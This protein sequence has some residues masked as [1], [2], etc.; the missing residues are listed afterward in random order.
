MIENCKDCTSWIWT[1]MWQ[2]NC[3]LHPSEKPMWSQS[4]SPCTRGCHDFVD[5]YAQPQYAHASHSE[6]KAG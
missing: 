3:T 1:G 2:G 4:A 5:K 6:D